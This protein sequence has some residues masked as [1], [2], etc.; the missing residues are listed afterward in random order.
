M[1]HLT[2]YS[3][4]LIQNIKTAQLILEALC[5]NNVPL[6]EVCVAEDGEIEFDWVDGDKEAIITISQSGRYVY[7]LKQPSGK[8]VSGA[9]YINA[10]TKLAHAF[11]NFFK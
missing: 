11:I 5:D 2:K 3:A 9:E 7:L 8:Y 1:L 10:D 6:P 4:N